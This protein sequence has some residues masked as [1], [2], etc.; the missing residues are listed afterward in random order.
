MSTDDNITESVAAEC[1]YI[2]AKLA[3]GGSQLHV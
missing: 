1:K 3:L 2:C